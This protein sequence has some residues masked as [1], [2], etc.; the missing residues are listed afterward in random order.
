MNLR[1]RIWRWW[2]PRWINRWK[3]RLLRWRKGARA[4][5]LLLVGWAAVTTGVDELVAR[6]T[7][8][9]PLSAG[10]LALGLYGLR[11]LGITLWRGLAA[12]E[13]TRREDLEG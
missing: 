1:A 5:T 4:P 7:I 10:L 8:V 13:E 11:R 9:W 12:L 2:A 6:P 3:P